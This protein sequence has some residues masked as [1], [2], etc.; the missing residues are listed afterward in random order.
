MTS[1]AL[2]R[3]FF[4]LKFSTVKGWYQIA[5]HPSRNLRVLLLK[6]KWKDSILYFKVPVGVELP[7]IW[8]VDKVIDALGRLGTLEGSDEI[9]FP[10]VFATEL[11][12]K[13]TP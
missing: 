7:F 9:D 8:R 13:D 2:F 10:D 3:L 4:Y 1:L 11:L 6:Y 5:P 12:K